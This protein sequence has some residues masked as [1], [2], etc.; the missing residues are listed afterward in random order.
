MIC[1]ISLHQTNENSDD[2]YK[3]KILGFMGKYTN[4]HI[5]PIVII[6]N[7]RLRLY[8]MMILN[9]SKIKNNYAPEESRT[10]YVD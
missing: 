4:T 2:K 7:K 9:S 3:E 1:P 6:M 10:T 5:M 8:R